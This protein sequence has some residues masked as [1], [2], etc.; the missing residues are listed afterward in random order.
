MESAWHRLPAARQAAADGDHRIVL[1]LARTAAGWTLAQAGQHAGYS[2]ATM[3][4]FET[5]A[6]ALR[7]VNTLR[8]F[9]SVFRIPSEMLGLTATGV[10][11]RAE[12]AAGVTFDADPPATGGDEPVHRR[13]FLF[14]LASGPILAGATPPSAQATGTP[15]SLVA[16]LEGML[17]RRPPAPGAGD[18]GRLTARLAAIKTDFQACRYAAV[19]TALPA[20]IADSTHH[21]AADPSAAAVLAEAYNTAANILIKLD[22]PGPGWIAA[23]RAMAA[24]RSSGN[25]VVAASVTRNMVSLCRRERR[26]DTAQQL[27]VEAAGG[28]DLTAAAPNP[29]QLSMYGLLMCNAGY[30]AAQA[31][32]RSRSDELLRLADEAAQRLGGDHNAHWSA[33]GP[34]NVTSHRISASVALGDAGTAIEHAA[35]IPSSSIRIAERG[36]RIW[37]DVARAYHHWQKPDKCLRALLIAERIAPEEVRQR[38]AVRDLVLDLLS[39]PSTPN[40]TGVRELA[41]RVG[42]PA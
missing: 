37:F 30:A 28:L 17:L 11:G 33:F 34:T 23:D 14:G 40:M 36:V 41:Q 26:F 13:A 8:H 3:S 9:A 31:G 21:G 19:T 22:T 24:A 42:C 10:A 1:R 6:R 5:G 2:A 16:G 25:P 38:P 18:P 32:D 20:L 15:G 29:A 27:A 39:A 4:R 7:D 35:T 12:P